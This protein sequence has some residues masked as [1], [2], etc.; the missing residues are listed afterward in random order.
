MNRWI[1]VFL[2]TSTITLA[3]RATA[4]VAPSKGVPVVT[5]QVY[6][7]AVDSSGAPVTDLT[8][9]DIAVKE[10]GKERQVAS[11]QPAVAP[12]QVAIL[13]EDG[14]LGSF[15]SGVA[16]FLQRSFGRGQFSITLLTPQASL[17]VDFTDD[18]AA[19]KSA[20]G[21]LGLRGRVQTD[22]DQ[23]IDAIARAAKALQQRKAERPIILALTVAGGQPES[24][25]PR[26][27]LNTLRSSGAGLNVVFV[28]GA[29]L[30]MVLGDGPGQSG[31]LLD[32]A[33]TGP[34]I[35][36]ALIKVA[37]RLLRQYLLTYTLPD[38]VNPADRLSVSTSR[39]GVTLTA[40]SRVAAK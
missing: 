31:G 14:G 10:G 23:M 39:T 2:V 21:R 25:D 11:L 13:V 29:E 28:T 38:G 18:V 16:Q 5:R 6:I 7:S 36:P 3:S 27:V 4:T 22:G 9:A 34:A 1:A 8:A 35:A 12:M 30:G 32:Q 37:D 17:V 26:D 24:V 40:P 20:I 33:S 15:Q 19:L